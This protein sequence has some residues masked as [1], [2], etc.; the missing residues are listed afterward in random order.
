M[1]S[2]GILFYLDASPTRILERTKGHTHRP[3][4][5]VSDPKEK[6]S[7]LLAKRAEFY[8]QANHSV[9]TNNMTV[10]E[11]AKRII[12]ILKEDGEIS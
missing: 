3:L 11:V 9:D 2:S 7:E 12:F 6:I 4:L 10:D 1:K 8:A 5:N